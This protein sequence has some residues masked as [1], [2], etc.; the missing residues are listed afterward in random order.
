[1]T[2]TPTGTSSTRS[3]PRLRIERMAEDGENGF[4][5]LLGVLAVNPEQR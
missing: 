1:M 4:A 2:R 5:D 3:T